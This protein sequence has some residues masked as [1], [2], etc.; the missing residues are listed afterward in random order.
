MAN[1]KIN[2]L[3]IDDYKK[4]ISG[5]VSRK[6]YHETA[7]IVG[8]VSPVAQDMAFYYNEFS[9]QQFEL[10]AWRINEADEAIRQGLTVYRVVKGGGDQDSLS[11]IPL[12]SY[13]QATVHLDKKSK[14]AIFCEG[15][16]LAHAPDHEFE[17]RKSELERLLDTFSDIECSYQNSYEAALNWNGSPI[18]C[19]FNAGRRMPVS[20]FLLRALNIIDPRETFY[21]SIEKIALSELFELKQKGWFAESGYLESDFVAEFAQG[22]LQGLIFDERQFSVW[23]Y[24][25]QLFEG[26]RIVFEGNYSDGLLTAKLQG[27][28]S[29]K[30]ALL[31]RSR[32]S[33]QTEPFGKFYANT[34]NTEFSARIPWLSAQVRLSFSS[35]RGGI[36]D[37]HLEIAEAIFQNPK[38]WNTKAYKYAVDSFLSLK[39]ESWRDNGEPLLEAKEFEA[40][41]GGFSISFSQ[42]DPYE[43]SFFFE[44]SNTLFAGHGV[45]I[46]GSLDQ[47]FIHNELIG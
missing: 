2:R 28:V 21:Q 37:R 13:I 22:Q 26:C 18:K 14:C 5:A 39:N 41:L 25:K 6:F 29:D 47:G 24:A 38:D 19:T 3:S 11:D 23:Y 15:E 40:L 32:P 34:S 4:Q 31:T 17:S 43:F 30:Q 46:S 42:H 20:K 1:I 33:I 35:V 10:A 45:V 7:H 44:T 8:L 36:D 27:D 16:I 9:I 12:L